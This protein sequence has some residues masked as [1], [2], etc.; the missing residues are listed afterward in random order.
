M[1]S[2][3]EPTDTFAGVIFNCSHSL[4]RI[5]C[6]NCVGIIE[7][8]E[9]FSH[10]IAFGTLCLLPIVWLRRKIIHLMCNLQSNYTHYISNGLPWHCFVSNQLKW[11]NI[12]TTDSIESL[13]HMVA[14]NR[15]SFNL[16]SLDEGCSTQYTHQS[17]ISLESKWKQKNSN[18]IKQ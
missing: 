1:T 5:Y 6:E 11:N 8:G 12:K 17:T 13:Q 3:D 18:Q 2:N 16:I 7:K 14:L 9:C 4:F 10:F 15:S